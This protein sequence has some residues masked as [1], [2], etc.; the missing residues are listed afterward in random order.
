MISLETGIDVDDI[1]TELTD[2]EK[3]NE[4]FLNGE[5]IP[6]NEI[7]TKNTTE[8]KRI[9]EEALGMES[10]EEAEDVEI[11]TPTIDDDDDYIAFQD[12]KKL[13]K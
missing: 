7:A 1:L 8:I 12:F 11:I 9:K 5:E 2:L 3:E 10:E 4:A 13:N 6:H